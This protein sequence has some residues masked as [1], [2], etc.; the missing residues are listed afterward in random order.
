MDAT[1]ETTISMPKSLVDQADILAQQLNISRSRL[2]AMAMDAL[3]K[4]FQ[5]HIPLDASSKTTEDQRAPNEPGRS[6]N[7]LAK[8]A[9]QFDSASRV[10]NQG[11]IFWIRPQTLSETE[12][13]YYP[14]PYVVIQDNILN[15]SRINTVVVCG[16]TSNLKQA[17]APGNVVLEVGEA[18]LPKRSVV[19]VSRVSAV[20]TSQL[21]ECIGSLNEQ[22]IQ[23]ILAG[24]R[25][26]QLSFFAR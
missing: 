12:L 19:D 9:T 14:H 1:I 5:A 18:N 13:G 7:D 21:G 4:N 2:F 8:A 26:L 6:P 3:I 15:Y 11:D 22:R 23:Q 16:L 10:V 20:H 24:M 17:N 25:F